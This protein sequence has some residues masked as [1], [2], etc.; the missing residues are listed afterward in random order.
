M[1]F[2]PLGAV[3]SD[4]EF[5]CFDDSDSGNVSPEPEQ[6]DEDDLDYGVDL[7]LGDEPGTSRND[8]RSGADEDYP[9]EVLSTEKI[10]EHMVDCIKDVNNVIQIPTTT[11]RILLNHFKWDKEKLMERYYSEEQE[12]MF[13][14][15]K[16]IP[17]HRKIV[18][19]PLTARSSKN[20][21]FECEICYLTL[22]KAVR[23]TSFF[24]LI[25]TEYFFIFL[26]HDRA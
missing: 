14:E 25:R 6:D 5:I 24:P 18:F 21:T 19:N 10:V 23:K 1:N 2:Q 20:A 17:P 3:M 4:D 12:A 9:F 16:V 26:E 7:G 11:V 22:P 13:T 8:Q 15:A